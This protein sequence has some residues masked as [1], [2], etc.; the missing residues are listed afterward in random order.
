M[1]LKS[2]CPSPPG[3]NRRHLWW[4]TMSIRCG[5]ATHRELQSSPRLPLVY[6]LALSPC[7][8]ESYDLVRRIVRDHVDVLIGQK[9]L[10]LPDDRSA[11]RDEAQSKII[12]WCIRQQKDEVDR[13]LINDMR[14]EENDWIYYDEAEEEVQF[15]VATLVPL[16]WRLV[17]SSF[18]FRSPRR[19]STSSW[20]TR[21]PGPSQSPITMRVL[22]NLFEIFSNALCFRTNVV[23]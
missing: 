13:L 19:Y 16:A 9:S 8:P 23:I 1:H 6:R 11:S 21:S 10:V 14:K 15:Q 7:R 20:P 2:I 3:I 12:R 5:K 4:R 17:D 22:L 18:C